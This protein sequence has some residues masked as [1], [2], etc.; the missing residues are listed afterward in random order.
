MR[1]RVFSKHSKLCLVTLDRPSVLDK[2]A[3]CAHAI[4]VADCFE[5]DVVA[6]DTAA[7]NVCG[8]RASAGW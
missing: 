3:A 6:T 7:V 2:P 4:A 5:N 8:V 1:I